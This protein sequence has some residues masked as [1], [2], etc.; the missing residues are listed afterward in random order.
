M[1]SFRPYIKH[2]FAGGWATDFG[3]SATVSPD[4]T[5]M[6]PIPFLTQAENVLYEL[7]GGPHKS[8]GTSNMNSSALNSGASI[9]GLYDFWRMG[10]AGTP[11]QRRIAVAGSIIYSDNADGT[12]SSIKTGVQ[13]TAVWSFATFDDFLIIANDASADVPMSYD[14][15]TF[16]NL[17]GS[18]PNFSFSVKHQNYHFAAGVIANPSTLYYSSSLNP[19]EWSGG[20]SG[21][22][23]IDPNDGDRITGLISHRNELWVFKGPHKG[24][25]HRITGTSNSTWARETFVEG[26]G[27]VAHNSIF[28]YGDDIA[29]MW[30]DGSIRTLSTTAA[31]GDMVESALTYPVHTW[32]QEHLTFN[33]L[34][35]VIATNDPGSGRAYIAIPTNSST[36]NDAMLVLDYRF[37]P[38][39]ISLLTAYDCVSIAP[40]LDAAASLRPILMLGGSDGFVRRFNQS[41]RT[42]AGTAISSRVDTPYL[43]YGVSHQMKTLNAASVGL[44]PHNDASFTFGWTR[45]NNAEQT[46]SVAQEGTDVLGTA[47]AN[48]FTLNTSTLG[49]A[50]FVDKWFSLEEGGE[51]RT[52]AYSF[53]DINN[54]ADFEM[55]HFGAFIEPGAESMEN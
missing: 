21:S 16:Q 13:T 54:N 10:T 25:I 7:D 36:S 29:F 8:P 49:G 53:R 4:Q 33:N 24:S 42:T 43:D 37:S 6:L 35:R 50:R 46:M 39:R 23:Q 3:P 27:A 51:F 2:I 12:F 30:I 40:V 32:L 28:R 1:P 17:A 55:H 20:T 26:V 19:E 15:T 31:F 9:R 14:G 47:A 52:I 48:Q 5:G 18:P 41:T 34:H 11:S 22:I 45:D 38:V 44:A